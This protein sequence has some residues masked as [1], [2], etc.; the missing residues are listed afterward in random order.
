MYIC[1]YVCVCIYIYI[2]MCISLELLKKCRI[3]RPP[4]QETPWP[5]GELIV[6]SIVRPPFLGTI[7]ML[8]LRPPFLGTPFVPS[9]PPP[10]GAS[11][12]W[13]GGPP[14]SGQDSDFF[15]RE[16]PRNL[17]KN[18]TRKKAELPARKIP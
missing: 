1:T 15:L 11:R 13:G 7:L 6:R 18:C 16:Y 9:R 2:Y 3:W 5:S 4:V 17:G 10:S 12:A 8:D 14:F